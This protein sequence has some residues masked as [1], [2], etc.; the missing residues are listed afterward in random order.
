[1]PSIVDRPGVMILSIACNEPGQTI[2]YASRH[3]GVGSA[4]HGIF[5]PALVYPASRG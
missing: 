2:V 3:P 5:A 1:M 4:L